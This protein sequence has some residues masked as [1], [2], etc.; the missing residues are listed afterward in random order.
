VTV[1]AVIR[2]SQD[3]NPLHPQSTNMSGTPVMEASTGRIAFRSYETWYIIFGEIANPK[4]LPLIVLHGG[5]GAGHD[6]LRSLGELSSIAGIPIIMY[7]QVGCARSTHI[8][9]A[10]PGTFMIELFLD[11]LQNL[12]VTLGVKEYDI[13]DKAGVACWLANM[14]SDSLP[15]YDD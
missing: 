1:V 10:P 11:E 3:K 2:R 7:D 15:V 13:L 6:Y 4:Q 5:P 9:D 14:Q 12:L 8:R